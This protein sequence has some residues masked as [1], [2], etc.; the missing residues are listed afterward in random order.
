MLKGLGVF[1]MMASWLICKFAQ[2]TRMLCWEGNKAGI[3]LEALGGKT[4]RATSIYPPL[5]SGGK[6]GKTVHL[7]QKKNLHLKL[8]LDSLLK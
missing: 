1:E 4:E 7:K 2:H 6:G 5:L 8:T 3:S